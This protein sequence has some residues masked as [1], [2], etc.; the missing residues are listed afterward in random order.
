MLI[1]FI[2][3]FIVEMNYLLQITIFNNILKN[4]IGQILICPILF[5]IV[6]FL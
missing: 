6:Y 1:L 2:K 4:K 5:F 3:L